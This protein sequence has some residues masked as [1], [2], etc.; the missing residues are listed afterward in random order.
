MK[1][2]FDK[3]WRRVFDAFNICVPDAA[4]VMPPKVHEICDAQIGIIQI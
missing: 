1:R 3:S 2:P 4:D